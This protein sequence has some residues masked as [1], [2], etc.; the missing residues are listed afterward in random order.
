MIVQKIK[1]CRP[2]AVVKY[3]NVSRLKWILKKIDPWFSFK[4]HVIKKNVQ[5]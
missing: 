2:L 1:K 4:L 5:K 3:D